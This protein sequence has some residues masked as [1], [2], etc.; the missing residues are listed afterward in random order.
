MS[1]DAEGSNPVAG[2]GGGLGQGCR[3]GLGHWA[4]ILFNYTAQAAIG[5]S[6]L[7]FWGTTEVKARG[8][9]KAPCAISGQYKKMSSTGCFAT[10]EP[11]M[12][13]L[14]LRNCEQP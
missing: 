7:K 13:T 6:I 1:D 3:L 14:M 4:A 9:A 10:L 8:G 12:R 5:D 2:G 11:S